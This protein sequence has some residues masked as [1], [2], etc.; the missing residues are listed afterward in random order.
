M[1]EIVTGPGGG[2][3]MPIGQFPCWTQYEGNCAEPM[4]SSVAFETH[5]QHT[6][7][8]LWQEPHQILACEGTGADRPITAGDGRGW[9]RSEG[10]GAKYL[11]AC[12]TSS[13]SRTRPDPG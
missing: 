3:E 11:T 8:R 1:R 5:Q 6:R 7:A 12:P 2:G 13:V 10:S 4:M 9:A